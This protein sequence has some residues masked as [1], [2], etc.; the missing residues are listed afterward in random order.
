MPPEAPDV[1]VAHGLDPADHD[2]VAFLDPLEA[3]PAGERQILLGR[4]G[5]LQQMALEPGAGECATAA[6][7]RVERR[8]KIADQHQLPGARQRLEDRHAGAAALAAP[9]RRSISSHQPAQ[10]D[11][12][13]HRRDAAAEQG[14]PLAAAHQEA[15]QR[16]QDQLGPVALGRPVGAG[17]IAGRAVIHRGRGSRHSHTLCA[18]SHSVSRT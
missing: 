9:G 14:Q 13:G 18:A 10:R 4:V 12:A 2:L 8:Q 17:D 5:D 15:R 1:I 11:P 6:L 7:M 3:D 16:D